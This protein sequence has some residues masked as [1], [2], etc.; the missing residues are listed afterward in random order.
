MV[1][2]GGSYINDEVGQWENDVF[3]RRVFVWN[4]YVYELRKN[5]INSI[6]DP[7]AQLAER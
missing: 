7:L 5:E 4:I 6:C 2:A 3:K 1:P